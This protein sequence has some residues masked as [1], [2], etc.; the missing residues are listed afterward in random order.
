M[1]HKDCDQTTAIGD[2]VAWIFSNFSR[3]S[4]ALN[5][6]QMMSWFLKCFF[7]DLAA[8]GSNR[9]ID[10]ISFHSWNILDSSLGRIGY[11]WTLKR[12]GRKWG[13]E[14]CIG[15]NSS[16]QK[17]D[18]RMIAI[19]KDL[20]VTNGSQFETMKKLGDQFVR[21]VLPL[22]ATSFHSP[23]PPQAPNSSKWMI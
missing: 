7:A 20:K 3:R 6:I 5:L 12:K 16:P 19:T 1:I 21:R 23:L 10:F 22:F 2:F 8:F 4:L 13:K 9:I 17:F 18:R 11:E 15:G 14:S